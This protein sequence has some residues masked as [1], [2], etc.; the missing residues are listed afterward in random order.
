MLLLLD[1]AV[2]S[3]DPFAPLVEAPGFR[4]LFLGSVYVTRGDEVLLDLS[5]GLDRSGRPVD[6]DSAHW[7]GSI[8]KSFAAAALISEVQRAGRSL[9]E[10]LAAFVPEWPADALRRDG[11]DCTPAWLLSHQCGLPHDGPSTRPGALSSV[12]GSRLSFVPG[13]DSAYSNLGFDL[14]GALAEHLA[15]VPYCAVLDRLTA[16]LDLRSTGCDPA[17]VARLAPRMGRGRFDLPFLV[18]SSERW[19]QVP[20]D[21]PASKVGPS[22]NVASTAVEL[23]RWFRGLVRGDVL[24]R[25]LT[26]AMLTPRR[27]R[28]ALGVMVDEQEYGQLVWHNGALSPH[29]YSSFVGYV[30]AT[31]TT[32]VVLLDRGREVLEPTA[33]GF[34]L[35]R[36]AHG[37]PSRWAAPDLLDRVLGGLPGAVLAGS[38]VP[39]LTWCAITPFLPGRDGALS[40]AL[41]PVMATS[42]LIA[43]QEVLNGFRPPDHRVVAVALAL[44]VAVFGLARWWRAGEPLVGPGRGRAVALAWLFGLVV[45]GVLTVLLGSVLP[46]AALLPLVILVGWYWTGQQ[47]VRPLGVDPTQ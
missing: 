9:D 47:E 15:G 2:A 34:A 18:L 17:S 46:L 6:R 32:V 26:R 41:G 40:W 35:A 11:V 4:D 39:L 20:W 29:G 7:V 21:A 31:D 36:L 12:V 33:V 3:D 38:P 1:T 5:R 25:D 8:S 42:T 44:E 10:P 28:R 16:P 30:G 24:D 23:T 27:D 37:G 13:T 14:A 19:L 43:I 22:G 45:L